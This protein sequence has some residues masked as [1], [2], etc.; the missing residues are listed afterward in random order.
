MRHDLVR[1]ELRSL[2]VAVYIPCIN[3]AAG[4]SPL[5][6]GKLTN[7]SGDPLFLQYMLLIASVVDIFVALFHYIGVRHVVAD[8][9]VGRQV[10][11]A[12]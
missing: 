10:M 9:Q 3:V 1:P 8:M 2:A 11:E 5:L 6:V 7:M 12:A 4:I